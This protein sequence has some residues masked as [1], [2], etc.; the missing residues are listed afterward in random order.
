MKTLAERICENAEITGLRPMFFFNNMEFFE[1]M[2]NPEEQKFITSTYRRVDNKH[3]LL[4]LQEEAD[5]LFKT[6][7]DYNYIKK[8][9]IGNDV[10]FLRIKVGEN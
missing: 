2:T 1:T 10:L 4:L 3:F 8:Q 9:D 6:Q 7:P 5:R